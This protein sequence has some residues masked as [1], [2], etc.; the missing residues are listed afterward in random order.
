[1]STDVA[2]DLQMFIA[3][4][5]S[6]GHDTAYTYD[7][8]RSRWLKFNPLTADLWKAWQA[9]LEAGRAQQSEPIDAASRGWL[10]AL[11][12]AYHT[13]AREHTKGKLKEVLAYLA[14]NEIVEGSV[15][16]PLTDEQIQR[17]WFGATGPFEF[18]R[19]IER[20]HGIGLQAFE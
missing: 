2:D 9:A 8:D 17:C 6:E 13:V 16:E 4:A 10:A 18:A 5:N 15:C 7:T 20:A 1:M 14:A 12:D 3:W 19:A 11:S